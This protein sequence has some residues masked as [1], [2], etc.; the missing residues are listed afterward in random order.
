MDPMEILARRRDR[1]W[2]LANRQPGAIQW[3][4]RLIMALPHIE[5]D[6]V[7]DMMMRN[8][9][10]FF[11][12]LARQLNYSTRDPM[13]PRRFDPAS[14]WY[15]VDIELVDCEVPTYTA[16]DSLE[17][18]FY[19]LRSNFRI[20]ILFNELF[21]D[22]QLPFL[23]DVPPGSDEGFEDVTA[24]E[25]LWNRIGFVLHPG[26][27]LPP[28]RP[29]E[30]RTTD[31]VLLMRLAIP[32]VDALRRNGA[33]PRW[34]LGIFGFLAE[35]LREAEMASP[36]ICARFTRDATSAASF[37][38]CIR[39]LYTGVNMGTNSIAAVA[40]SD[41][42]IRREIFR[43]LPDTGTLYTMVI[44]NFRAV[45]TRAEVMRTH[46]GLS[47]AAYD[48][49]LNDL[50]LA[51]RT[52]RW[53]ISTFT[54][55]VRYS[56]V[57][58]RIID[59]M[60]EME[61]QL[62]QLQVMEEGHEV[63]SIQRADYVDVEMVAVQR[64]ALPVLT[65]GQDIGSDTSS[66]D[67]QGEPRCMACQKVLGEPRPKREPAHKF[68]CCGA[69]WG[70]DC[71]EQW[72]AE[73]AKTRRVAKCPFCNST[74]FVA[75]D[76]RS[77]SPAPEPL[78]SSLAVGGRRGGRVAQH[79][80]GQ[81]PGDE[82]PEDLRGP[83]PSNHGPAASGSEEPASA[84]IDIP[85]AIARSPVIMS[86]NL[87]L[88]HLSLGQVSLGDSLLGYISPGDV[89][90]VRSSNP[91]SQRSVSMSS[92]DAA[93]FRPS[94][95]RPSLRTPSLTHSDAAVRSRP[96]N[97]R[98]SARTPSMTSSDEYLL[99]G[100][101]SPADRTPSPRPPFPSDPVRSN[102]LPSSPYPYQ[103][104]GFPNQPAGLPDQVAGLRDQIARLRN[105]LGSPG[106]FSETFD[107]QVAALHEQIERLRLGL[108]SPESVLSETFDVTHPWPHS[109]PGP[110]GTW[111]DRHRW[112]ERVFIPAAVET[113][114]GRSQ[115]NPQAL[116]R[117]LRDTIRPLVQQ[118]LLDDREN[119]PLGRI[120]NL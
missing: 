82:V 57:P 104:A 69:D 108:G 99:F 80:T 14:R 114:R 4:L 97:R 95:R 107:D 88:R 1:F 41:R 49:M 117:W 15:P 33:L 17:R 81:W 21:D 87:S 13:G 37:I 102:P 77:N 8:P 50:D 12:F 83:S 48:R 89:E 24:V 44:Q 103:M 70:A 74:D 53:N 20:L 91:L 58:D 30:Q 120:T 84:P 61:K 18:D 52:E 68:S 109:A 64:H 22:E 63:I 45:P 94:S 92:S 43:V 25:Q 106:S 59:E 27:D 79:R 46:P 26:Y 35:F 31:P 9:N 71:L 78:S 32:N 101:W 7:Y 51:D 90:S 16:P 115:E 6:P 36:G 42:A 10:V 111:D 5:L 34:P 73:A 39:E 100:A 19:A 23:T 98:P 67:S 2:D 62:N 55:A 60:M 85:G 3:A 28:Q 105:R 116:R 29:R 72:I 38:D 96:S 118:V 93:A 119:I 112:F 56:R 110:T 40:E 75:P 11:L 113:L 65:Q 86:G 54:N 47:P 76:G 66:D